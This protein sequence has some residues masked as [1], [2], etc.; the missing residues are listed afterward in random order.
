MIF[1]KLVSCSYSINSRYS[2]CIYLLFFVL[3]AEEVFESD[4][5]EMF[6]TSNNLNKGWYSLCTQR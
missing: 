4:E 5:D 1:Q 3:I 6:I 2:Y